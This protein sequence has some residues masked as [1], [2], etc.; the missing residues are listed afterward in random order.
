MR[1]NGMRPNG[2]RP[3]GNMNNRPG[4][5]GVVFPGANG[6]GGGGAYRPGQDDDDDWPSYDDP[7]YVR[8]V[9]LDGIFTVTTSAGSTH[10]VDAASPDTSDDRVE[11]CSVEWDEP[12]CSSDKWW[13]RFKV[14]DEGVGLNNIEVSP[15]NS[16]RAASNALDDK[17]RIIYYRYDLINDF[18]NSKSTLIYS[19][20]EKFPLGT[21]ETVEVLAEAS[22]CL[23]GI[24]LR[25]TDLNNNEGLEDADNFEED[26]R[27]EQDDDDGAA[28]T[29]AA[30][31]LLALVALT[32]TL[33]RNNE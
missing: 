32:G 7:S 14:R 11:G 8:Q 3:N 13:V 17:D 2:M 19:R 27:D 26:E 4:Q 28:A 1:P 18:R 30:P 29:M 10:T 12:G 9:E 31:G 24:T 23:E 16:N 6:V 15:I 33:L 20:Y 25:V 5:D 21:T 22:C